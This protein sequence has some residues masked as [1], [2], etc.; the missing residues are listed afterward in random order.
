MS[1]ENSDRLQV[2]W[3]QQEKFMQ[4]LRQKRSFPEFPVDIQS[5]DGQKFLKDITH[6]CMH[7]LFEANVELKNSKS[8]RATEIKEI[9]RQSYITELIDSLHYF[10]EIAIASGITLDELYAA[11]IDKGNTN[12]QRILNGY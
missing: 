8:H 4:L 5:K 1:N 7:E 6:E 12:T 2:M 9:D 3:E 11:Y 10:F